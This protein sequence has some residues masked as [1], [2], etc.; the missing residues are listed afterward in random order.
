VT[1]SAIPVSDDSSNKRCEEPGGGWPVWLAFAL[2]YVLFFVSPIFLSSHEMLFFKYVPPRDPI[3]LDLLQ[4]LGFSRAWVTFHGTPYISTNTYPP[5]TALLYAPLLGADFST[6]YKVFTVVNLACYGALT[7]I[8]PRRMMNVQGFP[9][10][11][12]LIIVTGL[13]SYGLQFELER[14]QFNVIAMLLAFTAILIYHQHPRWRVVAYALFVLSVQLK[15]YPYIFIVMLVHDWHNWRS[16][17]RRFALLTAANVAGFFILGTRIFADWVNAVREH[18][19]DPTVWAGN[20]SIQAFVTLALQYLPRHGGA[21]LEPYAG[22]L[23]FGLLLV[24]LA[25]LLAVVAAA[26]RGNKP[27]VNAHLLLACALAALVLPA[28]SNDY[29]LAVLAAPAGAFF[30]ANPSP[31]ASAG[32]PLR[33]ARVGA[34]M[35]MSLAYASTLFSSTNKPHFL[36]N[37][38][39]ALLAM[40]VALTV[41]SWLHGGAGRRPVAAVFARGER[42]A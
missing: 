26:S 21:W 29:T 35:I 15:L 40:L 4:T 10:T 23:Q 13:V 20:H 16:N 8:L 22:L 18:S 27:G 3:G 37:N 39:P 34:V 38:F 24:V 30:L 2:A 19:A 31:D 11:F 1:L 42:G 14:G 9:A 12:V 33:A 7:C 6:L 28:V 36:S 41:S 32:R 17:V 5:V 25:C